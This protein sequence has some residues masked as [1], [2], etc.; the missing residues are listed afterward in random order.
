MLIKFLSSRPRCEEKMCRH[1]L[2]ISNIFEDVVWD[3]TSKI[4][5]G[6][7]DLVHQGGHYGGC[8]SLSSS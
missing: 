7:T 1:T 3:A 5:P 8:H 4:F 2:G 6:I